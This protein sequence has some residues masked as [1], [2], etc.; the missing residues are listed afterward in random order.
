MDRAG[1]YVVVGRSNDCDVVID[2]G[3]VSARHACL[4]WEGDRISIEDLGSANGTFVD[5]RMVARAQVRPGD[6]VVFGRV[7]LAWSEDHMRAFLRAGPR[8]TTIRSD[9]LRGRPVWGRR[10]VCGACHTRGLLPAGFDRGELTCSSCGAHLVLGDDRSERTRRWG[11]AL[12]G[13]VTVMTSALMA[14]TVAFAPT[15]AQ[16]AWERVGRA[17]GL[18]TTPPPAAAASP[19]EASIRARIAARI[20][21]AID[22]NH[23]RTRNLAVRIAADDDGPFHVEQVA[24]LWSHV[25]T[26]WHYVSDPRGGEYFAQASETIENGMAGDC[27]DFA[28]VIIAMVQSI[29]GQGRMV[30]VDGDDGGHAY[31]EVCIEAPPEEVAQRLAAFYRSERAPQHADVGDIHYRSDDACPVWLNLDWN[32]RVPGGGYGRERWAVAIHPDGATET[33]AAALGDAPVAVT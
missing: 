17:I 18:M 4:R 27:D 26:N 11:A 6:E 23:P 9:T 7:P 5:G 14:F 29:G 10:F 32:A 2:D 19:E 31:A 16:Q 28:A 13:A 8:R 25:R 12:V 24:R 33:L 3:S 20:S 30:M 22:P 15:R 1:S 21:A